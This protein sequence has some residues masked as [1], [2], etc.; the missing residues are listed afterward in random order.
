VSSPDII[1]QSSR[2]AGLI[3]NK[4]QGLKHKIGEILIEIIIIVFAITLSLL[5]E[6]WR[7]NTEDHDLQRRFLQGLRADLVKDVSELKASSLKWVSMKQAATYFLRPEQ[8]IAWAS[9]STAF[10]AYKLFHNVYFFPNSNRYEALKSTGKLDVIEDEQLQNNIIDL[11]QTKI[12]DLE[13]QISFFNHFLNVQVK[14]HLIQH[15]KRDVNNE[16]VLDRD[17][18]INPQ[19]RN[20]LSFYADLD[21]VLKRAN[22]AVSSSESILEGIDRT[23]K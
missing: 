20:I 7:Q 2:I 17:F 11:Y 14:D 3:K 5:F 1:K 8:A 18:F 15:F 16:V 13:Q 23:L 21:D 22:A 19:I 12:P 4:G 6:R 9:D 10:Y